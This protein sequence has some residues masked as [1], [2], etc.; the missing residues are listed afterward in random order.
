MLCMSKGDRKIVLN[1]DKVFTAK[2]DES[3]FNAAL[4]AG[5]TLNHSC[6]NGRCNSCKAF[7]ESGES[8]CIHDEV[9]LSEE[10][11]I[12]G[13][14]LTCSR[15]AASD[16]NLIIE[17]YIDKVLPSRK[18]L[19][20]KVKSFSIFNNDIIELELRL[21]PNQEF[22]FEPGQYVNLIRGSVK[23]SY[24]IANSSSENTLLF[25]I[26]YYPSGQMSKYLFGEMNIDDLFRIEGPIGTFFYR[27]TPMRNLVF[28][29][30]GTGIAPVKSM[31]EGLAEQS[32]RI[33]GK[34]IHVLW[35]NRGEEDFFWRPSFQNMD[36]S[37]YPCISRPENYSEGYKQGYVQ[38]VLLNENVDMKDSIVYAC[39]SERMINSARTLLIEHGLKAQSFYSDAFVISN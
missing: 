13:N 18:T 31:L 19:P 7:V 20:A 24:S 10:E 35:G 5:L 37:F 29:A 16:L 28:L 12:A 15:T 9:G 1:N 8:V 6:L 14:I 3:I 21:P 38:E 11:S 17:E 33:L 25:Y 34:Q 36:V 27:D 32:D 4:R 26:R 23:R 2:T 30:T 39:G 22:E